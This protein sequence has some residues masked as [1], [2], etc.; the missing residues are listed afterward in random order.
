M[1][2]KFDGIVE[3]TLRDGEHTTCKETRGFLLT[4]SST[5]YLIACLIQVCWS[6][7]G[8]KLLAGT[9]S[10]KAIQYG[11]DGNIVSTIQLPP[12]LVDE[13]MLGKTDR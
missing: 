8:K 6:T 12:S 13:P 9:K 2:I 11:L 1:F 5:E 10:G 3:A 7:D 4:L